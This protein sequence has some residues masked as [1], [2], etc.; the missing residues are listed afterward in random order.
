MHL[1]AALDEHGADLPV[2]ELR[3]DAPARRRGRRAPG[4]RTT[5]S[6]PPPRAHA[7]APRG[8]S[9]PT[10]TTGEAMRLAA[11]ISRAIAGRPRRGIEHHAERLAAATAP[12]AERSSAGSSREHGA[13]PDHDGVGLAAEA[14]GFAGAPRSP[15]IH[16]EAPWTSAI[17]PS[18]V[19]AAFSVT[20][21]RPRASP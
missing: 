15:V 7:R 12:R 17:L 14:M 4:Q 19:M 10:A 2:E 13:D 1:G 8:A 3:Q 16:F 21:G 11:W 20:C 9:A 5:R 6:R 18:S